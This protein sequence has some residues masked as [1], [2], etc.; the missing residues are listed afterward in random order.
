MLAAAKEFT[1]LYF[2]EISVFITRDWVVVCAVKVIEDN[3]WMCD[4]DVSLDSNVSTPGSSQI[5][6]MV[7]Y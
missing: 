5:V 6:F 4:L 2:T 1:S 7:D 3:A